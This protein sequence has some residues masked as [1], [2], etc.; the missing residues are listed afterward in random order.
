MNWQ[1][2]RQ[3]ATCRT[4]EDRSS[5]R[6][7]KSRGRNELRE[8][9]RVDENEMSWRAKIRVLNIIFSN[10]TNC[11]A[12]GGHRFVSEI[13]VG[14]FL[15]FRKYLRFTHIYPYSKRFGS[16]I[17]KNIYECL[18]YSVLFCFDGTFLFV[19]LS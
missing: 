10:E 11:V 13:R 5:R 16:G 12:T 9:A 18:H 1:V 8:V 7:K 15:S 14:F 3:E 4:R 17:G 19:I 6:R 2:C